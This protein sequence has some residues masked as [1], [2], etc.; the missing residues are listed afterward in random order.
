MAALGAARALRKDLVAIIA[1]AIAS[2]A[3]ETAG[4]K[5]IHKPAI[6]IAPIKLASYTILSHPI[7]RIHK[8]ISHFRNS[9]KGPQV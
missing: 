1:F 5:R 9:V 8:P 3:L 7:L 2:C 6:A 4:R